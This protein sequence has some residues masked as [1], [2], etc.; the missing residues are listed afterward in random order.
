MFHEDYVYISDHDIIVNVIQYVLCFTRREF[1]AAV[2]NVNTSLYQTNI[3]Q[4]Y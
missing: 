1:K 3:N 4:D 2:N